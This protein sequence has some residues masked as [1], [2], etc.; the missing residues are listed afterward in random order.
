MWTTSFVVGAVVF[1]SAAGTDDHRANPCWRTHDVME[2]TMEIG[3]MSV[4]SIIEWPY[5]QKAPCC[6]VSVSKVDKEK[7][8]STLT[9]LPNSKVLSADAATGGNCP[10]SLAK[11]I[12]TILTPPN[13]IRAPQ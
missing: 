4:V 5:R 8:R 1:G 6:L 10:K 7:Q 11:T 13:G 2:V 9:H 3:M 12:L